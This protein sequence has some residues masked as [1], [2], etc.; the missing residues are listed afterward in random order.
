[1]KSDCTQADPTAA[2]NQPKRPRKTSLL[3]STPQSLVLAASVVKRACIDSFKWD[4]FSAG[5][6]L[7]SASGAC[8]NSPMIL[9]A[10][11]GKVEKVDVPKGFETKLNGKCCK[12]KDHKINS[13]GSYICTT[14]PPATEPT[15]DEPTTECLFVPGTKDIF[16]R[17]TPGFPQPLP[18]PPTSPAFRIQEIPGKG[19]GVVAAR[20]LKQGDLLLTERPLLMMP[21]AI[22]VTRPRTFTPAQ[23]MQHSP[24]ESE[25]Y[26][27][28]VVGRME[29]GRREA[30]YRLHNSHTEDGSGPIDG[31]IR[32]NGIG[33]RGLQPGVAGAIGMYTAVCDVVARLNHSCSP[34]TQPKFNRTMFAFEVYA[35]REVAEGEELTFQYFDAL[36]PAEERAEMCTPYAFKCSCAACTEPTRESDARRAEIASFMPSVSAWSTNPALADDWL[37]DRCLEQLEM[38]EREGLQYSEQY[39]MATQTIMESYICLGDAERASQWAARVKPLVWSE[40]YRPVDD[41]LDPKSPAYAGHVLWRARIDDCHG[42]LS[43]NCRLGETRMV[44]T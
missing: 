8:H 14:M 29:K 23:A 28:I 42:G 18:A 34:N 39:Y 43:S 27:E 32:T 21:L 36:V 25:R 19:L 12:F 11:V 2:N 31:R 16:L 30:F 35:V 20:P 5:A 6:Q 33:L 41:F 17:N 13:S 15:T 10:P 40:H 24:N 37:V 22:P 3:T 44:A 38:L 7:Y 9:K 26:A 1:M 4:S